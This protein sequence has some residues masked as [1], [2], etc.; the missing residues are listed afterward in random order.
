[1][2]VKYGRNLNPA[3]G[4]N[5]FLPYRFYKNIMKKILL[6]VLTFILV[7]NMVCE[8]ELV[9]VEVR[10]GDTL[11]GFA[12]KYL[13]DPSRWPR[14]YEINKKDVNDPDQIFPGQIIK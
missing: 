11:H 7:I 4:Q 13:K 10:K 12:S 5:L 2:G 8:A 6:T 14:I 3:R 9:E 1:M